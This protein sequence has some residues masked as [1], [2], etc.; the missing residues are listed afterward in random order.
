MMKSMKKIVAI[1]MLI[2]SLATVN[3]ASAMP[4]LHRHAH[5][6][7]IRW[8]NQRRMEHVRRIENQRRHQI[9]RHIMHKNMRRGRW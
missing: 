1:A 2:G 9:Q 5:R 6:P 4:H 3:S 8:E 7:S